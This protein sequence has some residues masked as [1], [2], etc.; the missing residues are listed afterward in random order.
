LVRRPSAG[1]ANVP[2]VADLKKRKECKSSCVLCP[3]LFHDSEYVRELAY[4]M[5]KEGAFKDRVMP[6]NPTTTI[7]PAD[8]RPDAGATRGPDT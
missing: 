7:L 2:N 5:F 3:F 1:I 6:L 4:G 8:P